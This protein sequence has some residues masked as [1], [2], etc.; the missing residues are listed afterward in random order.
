MPSD[1]SIPVLFQIESCV[2]D[3][4]SNTRM[5]PLKRTTTNITFCTPKIREN[6]V[7][8]TQ[9]TKKLLHFFPNLF[10]RAKHQLCVYERRSGSAF[11][12]TSG[13]APRSS[14]PRSSRVLGQS[15]SLML[16]INPCEFAD[17]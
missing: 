10:H 7:A 9:S 8:V 13:L 11:D 3:D 4:P 16:I 12:T 2:T 5:Y 17:E 1:L 6:L 14:R 15:H